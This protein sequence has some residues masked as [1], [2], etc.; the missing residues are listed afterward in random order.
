MGKVIARM[1]E[2]RSSFNILTVKSAEKR[3]LRRPRRI[4]EDYI[5]IYFKEM[6]IN[7]RNWVDSTK[8]WRALVYTAS[9]L[10]VA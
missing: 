5:R 9:N 7:T 6:G 8:V 1:K 3:L 10:R 2:G 4:W